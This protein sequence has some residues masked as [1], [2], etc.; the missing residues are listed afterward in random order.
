[1]LNMRNNCIEEYYSA[2][3]TIFPFNSFYEAK[4]LKEFKNSL[5]EYSY[6]NTNC[7]YE[8]LVT[9]FGSPQEVYQDYMN[10]QDPESKC[11]DTDKHKFKKPIMIVAVSIISICICICIF[12]YLINLFH[13]K[14]QVQE[15]IPDEI[16]INIIE[17]EV[18]R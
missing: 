4:F 11:Y 3:K 14:E 13:L 17:T 5:V 12:G 6:H 10:A 9:E 1:M 18:K 2:L 15:T 16:E 7:T 8:D